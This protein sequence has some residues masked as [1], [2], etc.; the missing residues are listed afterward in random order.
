[1]DT[2]E[3]LSRYFHALPLLLLHHL[4]S[5][6]AMALCCVTASSFGFYMV[7]KPGP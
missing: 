3:Y 7:A 2:R 4:F 6:E 1:M 5:Y